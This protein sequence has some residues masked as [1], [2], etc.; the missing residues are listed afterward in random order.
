MPFLYQR[1]V[2]KNADLELGWPLNAFKKLPLK[3][4]VMVYSKFT[5]INGQTGG[6]GAELEKVVA[7]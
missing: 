4:P 1:G 2:G 7:G 6:H 3:L 5:P